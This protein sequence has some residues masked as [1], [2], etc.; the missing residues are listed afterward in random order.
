MLA[1]DTKGKVTSDDELSRAS[2]IIRKKYSRIG[3]SKQQSDSQSPVRQDEYQQYTRPLKRS[4][5]K[6][7]DF[8]V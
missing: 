7:S 2:E 1:N 5:Q 3:A 8:N 4:P 6:T